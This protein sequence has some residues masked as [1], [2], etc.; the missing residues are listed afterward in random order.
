[1]VGPFDTSLKAL[2]QAHPLD[3]ARFAGRPITGPVELIDT[4]LSTI[5]AEADKVLRISGLHTF[6][7]HLELQ[8]T[9]DPH[10]P[11]RVLMYND[12]LTYR[13]DLPVM[14]VVILLRPAADGR[15]MSGVVSRHVEGE[16]PYLEFRYRVVRIWEVP[17]DDV[18][19]WGT[20]ALPLAP[21]A[22]GADKRLPDVLVE[23]DRRI[24][25][26]T[27]EREIGELWAITNTLMGLKY[28]RDTVS[29]ILRGVR[30]MR[31]S[32][33]YQMI[34]EEGRV[35]GRAEGKLEA[36]QRVLALLGEQRFHLSP[37]VAQ[38]AVSQVRSAERLDE[39]LRKACVAQSWEEVFPS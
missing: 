39:L 18:L 11:D 24:Q 17:V 38:S 33:T 36:M 16:A 37:E 28:P 10:L 8:S 26:E 5:A 20:G 12:L 30:R 32:V 31:E 3:W 22:A 2:M 25:S 6:L 21:L 15:N 34:L 14:S 13:H 9:Y 1:M 29:Q 7:L 23:M 19:T 27:S 4:D 35:E